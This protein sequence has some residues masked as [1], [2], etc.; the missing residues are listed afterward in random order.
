MNPTK[1]STE[2]TSNPTAPTARRSF[3]NGLWMLL[4]GVALVELGWVVSDFLFPK[5]P[6]ANTPRQDDGFVAGPVDRFEI[7]SVTPL[8]KAGIYLVRLDS[9]GFLALRRECTHLGCTVAWNEESKRFFCPCHASVFDIRGAVLS[10][11]APRPLQ[12]APIRIENRIVKIDLEQR[13]KRRRYSP[14]Q[15]VRP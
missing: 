11:P 14:S 10:P 6:R 15:A 1:T 7:G 5:P 13:I 8:P 3:L 2:S 9:G 12:L 4:G